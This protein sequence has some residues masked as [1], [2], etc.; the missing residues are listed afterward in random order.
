MCRPGSTLDDGCA[1]GAR[2]CLGD[3]AGSVCTAP[4]PVTDWV[5]RKE[6]VWASQCVLA[7]V[8]A[9]DTQGAEREG[10]PCD[11]S[12][13]NGHLLRFDCGICGK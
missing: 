8:R 1:K 2:E 11:R 7:T 9:V 5:S 12:T 3:A 13:I 10:F 4:S 6:A